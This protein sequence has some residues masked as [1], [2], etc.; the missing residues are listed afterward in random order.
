MRQS[1]ATSDEKLTDVFHALADT[2]R[3]TLLEKLRRGPAKVTD[4]AAPFEMSLPAVSKHL[5]VLE[6]ARLI[7]REVIGREHLC[8]LDAAALADAESWLQTY[9]IFWQQSL[10]SL[11]DFLEA[12]KIQNKK[13]KSKAKTKPG[14][15][16]N[17]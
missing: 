9:R 7:R 13:L 3:R 10:E 11:D 14:S 6:N 4:L 2:T 5:R 15:K 12:E 1:I 8:S 16:K 17:R